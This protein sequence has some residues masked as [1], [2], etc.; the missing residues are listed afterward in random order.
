MNPL[1]AELRNIQTSSGTAIGA[2]YAWDGGQYCAIHTG[3]GMIGCGIFDIASADNFSMAVAIAKG[4]PEHPLCEPE[5]LFQA[6]IV[7]SSKEATKLGI[8][9]GMTGLEALEKMLAAG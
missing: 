8:S 5:D 4:T 3:R 9:A 7:A 2:A 1:K 6:R